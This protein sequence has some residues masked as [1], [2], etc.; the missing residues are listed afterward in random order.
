MPADVLL[1]SAQPGFRLHESHREVSVQ[2]GPGRIQPH[3]PVQGFDEGS[4]VDVVAQPPHSL[5]KHRASS[6]VMRG[7]QVKAVSLE[8][9]MI[10]VPFRARRPN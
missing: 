7:K 2:L 6:R 8:Q 3:F 5:D 10:S 1:L 9:L 4:L